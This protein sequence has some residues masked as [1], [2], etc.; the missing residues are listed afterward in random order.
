[1]KENKVY[2]STTIKKKR[3]VTVNENFL[4]ISWKQKWAADYEH[5]VEAES[6]HQLDPFTVTCL[7]NNKL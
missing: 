5:H 7:I 6:S 4:Y 3:I 2:K 1:M